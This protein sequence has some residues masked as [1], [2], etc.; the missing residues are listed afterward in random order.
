MSAGKGKGGGDTKAGLVAC[1]G[2]CCGNAT[3]NPEIDHA[4][5]LVAL[6][7]IASRQPDRV[8][9]EITDCLGPCESAN[10]VVLRPSPAGRR[11]GGRPVWLSGLDTAGLQALQQWAHAGGPGVAPMPPV[12]LGNE[13]PRPRKVSVAS[14]R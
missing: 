5:E 2:C 12:L 9:L 1:R 11:R 8:G 7:R 10:V 6:R 3:K 14:A 4:A 13:I